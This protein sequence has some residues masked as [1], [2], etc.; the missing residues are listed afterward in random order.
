[1]VTLTMLVFITKALLLV[2]SLLSF[3]SE[4]LYVQLIYDFRYLEQKGVYEFT[5]EQKEL[6]VRCLHITNDLLWAMSE[7]NISF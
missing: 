1:M 2:N 4:S 7:H 6:I 3:T 5:K